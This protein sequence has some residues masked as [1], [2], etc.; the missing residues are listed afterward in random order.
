MFIGGRLK[1]KGLNAK[2]FLVARGLGLLWGTGRWCA[3]PSLQWFRF[4][5]GMV[6][7]CTGGLL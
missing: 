5:L 2:G 4:S 3:E 7:Q 1:L 6:S